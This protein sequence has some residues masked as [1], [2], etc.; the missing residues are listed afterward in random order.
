MNNKA[1]KLFRGIAV[2]AM[3]LFWGGGGIVMIVVLIKSGWL[4]TVVF[5]SCVGLAALVAKGMG[6]VLDGD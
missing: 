2:G 3:Y 6:I 5:F 4:V 1:E